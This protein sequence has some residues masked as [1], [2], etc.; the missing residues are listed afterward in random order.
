ME[1]AIRLKQK[2]ASATSNFNLVKFSMH[3]PP[4][5]QEELVTPRTK[6]KARIFERGAKKQK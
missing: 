4:L 2:Y 6:T 3:Q 1:M 5:I